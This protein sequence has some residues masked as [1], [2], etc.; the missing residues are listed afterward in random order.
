MLSALA[1]P[2]GVDKW[3]TQP[4]Y[5]IG[6]AARLA[7]VA[8]VTVRRWLYGYAP[9]TSHPLYQMPPVFGELRGDS[10]LI[11]FLQLIEIVVASDFRMAGH[12]PLQVVRRAYGVARTDWQ[13][14][15]PFA[16]LNL[17]AL[18]GHIIRHIRE[19]Q[20]SLS[21]QSVDTPVQ[22]TLPGLVRE[23]VRKL[24]YDRGWASRWH[25]LGTSIPIVVDPQ[26]GSGAPTITGRGLTVGTLYRRWHAGQSYRF[27][28]DDLA[29]DRDVVEDALRYAQDVAA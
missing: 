19:D 21:A 7:H 17:E 9:D 14:E 10:P 8:P 6:D 16:H 5:T 15:Y 20:G 1:S 22:W 4:M 11:S 12:V 2:N 29:L 23:E 18:G 13:V 24:D 25:P 26:Y 28:A 27:I 3:R